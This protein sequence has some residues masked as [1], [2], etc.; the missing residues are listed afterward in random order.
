MGLSIPTRPRRNPDTSFRQIGDE[1]GL[2]VLPGRA[3]VKVLNP[4]GIKIYAL[5]NGEHTPE[6]IAAEVATEFE[7]PA[8]QALED[9]ELFLRELS[10]HGMLVADKGASDA[11]ETNG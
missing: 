2:V 3:E 9:V 7:V 1:G 5:L 10:E 6:Q 4:A 11:P 8:A